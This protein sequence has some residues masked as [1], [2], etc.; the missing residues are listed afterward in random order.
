MKIIINCDD[1]G[2]SPRVNEEVFELMDQGCVTSATM[3]MNAPFLEDAVG[4][5]GRHKNCSFGVHLNLTQFKPFTS[6]PGLQPLLNDAGEFSGILRSVPPGFRWTAALRQGVFAE[7]S[8]QIE[9]G[10]ALGIP[11]SHLDSHHHVHTQVGLL[12]V[13]KQVLERFGIRRVRLRRNLGNDASPIGIGRRTANQ[14]WNLALRHYVHAQTTD[15]FA[16]FATFHEELCGGRVLPGSI[17]LMCHPGSDHFTAETALLRGEWM[18][19]M[20]KQA[21][22]VSY[23]DLA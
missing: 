18:G 3:M 11:I 17:E 6:H 8:T 7:W 14:A 1:L 13:L 20:S 15:L 12:G 16:A 2:M 5:I 22:L 23:H 10:L 21:L 4:Q 9:R 19:S